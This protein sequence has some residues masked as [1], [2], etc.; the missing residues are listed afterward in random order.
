MRILLGLLSVFVLLISCGPTRTAY[1]KEV[2]AYQRGTIS[3]DTSFVYQL[4]Y[5]SDL[6][7]RVVQGYFSRFSHKRRAALDFKLKPGSPVLAARDGIVVRVK[8]DG[9]RGG[10]NRKYR[11][12]GNHVIIQ[13][14]DS[15]RTGYWHLRHQSVL[16][17][18]GD[19]VRAGQPIG[20]S[21]KTGYALF[22]HLHFLAWRWNQGNWQSIGTRFVTSKGIRYLRVGKRYRSPSH[23]IR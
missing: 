18:V 14:S 7:P 16:V 5:P 4:P 11:A 17:R 1:Q 3:E 20:S 13:H 9:N 12:D 10:W 6:R 21:G 2:R 15:T 23:V 8:A 22:P 19:N